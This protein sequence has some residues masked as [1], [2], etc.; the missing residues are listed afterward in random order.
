MCG[1]DNKAY[2]RLANWEVK[3]PRLNIMPFAYTADFD[4]FLELA[5]CAII[6]PSAGVFTE[7]LIKRTPVLTF[8]LASTNDRG[9]LTM[10]NKYRLGEVCGHYRD[11]GRVLNTI[12]DH[13]EFYRENIDKLLSQYPCDWDEQ[14]AV[15]KQIILA[16][17]EQ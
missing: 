5:D 10:I 15:L 2:E 7:S 6:R 8:K 13:K 11:L 14:C 9:S 4:E 1:N 12:L 17:P 16:S 3:N